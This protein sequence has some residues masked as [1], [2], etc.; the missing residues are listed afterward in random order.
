MVRSSKTFLAL[1]MCAVVFFACKNSSQKDEKSSA[2]P[3][4]ASC[5][6]KPTA[7]C[8]GDCEVVGTACYPT[9]AYCGK[10]TTSTTCQ[11][12]ASCTW[13]A[14]LESCSRVEITPGGGST[15]GCSSQTDQTSCATAGCFWT[16]PSGPCMETAS[17][18][19]P[20]F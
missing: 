3:R 16:A 9:S 5:S 11:N 6:S 4:D 12:I 7:D 19:C 1:M 10:F 17:S 14:S 15:S 13:N 8:T 2:G 20:D 18:T